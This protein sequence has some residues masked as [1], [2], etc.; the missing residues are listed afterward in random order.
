MHMNSNTGPLKTSESAQPVAVAEKY[1]AVILA[2]LAGVVLLFAAGF[3]E[4]SV[5]HSAAHDSRH[6]V[7]F[8]CH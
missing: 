7:T 6:S 4:T 5:L 8:P 1:S 3:A 2:S